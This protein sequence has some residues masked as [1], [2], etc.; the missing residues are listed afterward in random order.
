VTAYA[1]T[2]DLISPK[3]AGQAPGFTMRDSRRRLVRGF[4]AAIMEAATSAISS[5]TDLWTL[6][7]S[8][9]TTLISI[10]PED[11]RCRTQDS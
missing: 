5:P 8:G 6:G 4:D 3:A 1:A 11:V 2:L 10:R 7:Y 9:E